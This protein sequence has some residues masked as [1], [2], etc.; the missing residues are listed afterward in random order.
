MQDDSLFAFAGLWDRWRDPTDTVIESCTILTTTPNS[1]LADVH[2]RM[3]VILR[4]DD[5]D[6]WLDP[7]FKDVKALAE[8]LAPFDAAQMKSFSVST[9]IN[10]VANDDP[11]CVVPWQVSPPAQ[12]AL[13]S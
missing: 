1:L 10:A 7:G 8:V 4:R 11:E 2:D 5:Y 3:P 13:F 12:G 6:Q 9:R